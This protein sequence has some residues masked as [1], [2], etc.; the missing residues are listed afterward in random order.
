MDASHIDKVR[1]LTLILTE[2]QCHKCVRLAKEKGI[3]GGMVMIGRGTVSSSILNFLGIKSEKKEIV[4]F[5]LI[6]EKAEEMLD[7]FDR[8]LQLAKPGHGIAYITPVLS[9]TGFSGQKTDKKQVVINT[10]PYMEEESMF[11]KLTVIVDRGVSDEVMD[12]ARS[13]GVRGGTILHGRGAGADIA[14]KLFG[15]EIEPE[16]ELVIIL[17]PNHLID[18]VVN[19][20]SEGLQLDEPGKGVLFVE[21]ILDAR[22]LL[23]SNEMNQVDN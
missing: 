13:A 1:M 16:K 3:R 5:L 12:I 2:N 6:K 9:G 11:K 22:G 7:Y 20:L 8:E 4:N 23:E 21:P 18:K 14:T 17:T 10:A 19:A 15:I